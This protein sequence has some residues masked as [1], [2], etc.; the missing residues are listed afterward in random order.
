MLCNDEKELRNFYEYEAMGV[1]VMFKCPKC[2]NC[3]DCRKGDIVE[4][5]SIKGEAEQLEINE[6]LEI[7]ENLKRIVARL[8]FRCDPEAALTD[9]QKMAEN[10]LERLCTKYDEK[11]KAV[12]LKAINKLHKNGHL[13]FEDEFTDEIREMI[14]SKTGY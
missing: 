5:I 7:N 3:Y 11:T 4:Q 13:L 1:N 10:A 8:P 6:S 2:R 12:V 9:N 14:A